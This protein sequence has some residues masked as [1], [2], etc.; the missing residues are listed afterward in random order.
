MMTRFRLFHQTQ[1]TTC[2]RTRDPSA[3][4]V[5][6]DAAARARFGDRNVT[7][8]LLRVRTRLH[9]LTT[10]C[11]SRAESGSEVSADAWCGLGDDGGG[12]R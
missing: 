12:V 7:D 6:R 9:M 11:E 5:N 10:F 3:A 8:V 1:D 4:A 2:G